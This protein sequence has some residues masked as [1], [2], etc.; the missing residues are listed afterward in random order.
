MTSA[1]PRRHV[2]HRVPP[3]LTDSLRGIAWAEEHDI[4]WIDGNMLLSKQG[5]IYMNH[6]AP[7]GLAA[8]GFLPKGDKRKVRNLTDAQ[9]DSL[10]SPD[11][12]QVPTLE[13]YIHGLAR[14]GRKGELEA[15]DDHRFELPQ[16]WQQVADF[17]RGAWGR[18]W[19]QHVNG[20]VLTNLSGGLEYALNVCDAGHE[21]GV[22]MIILPRKGARLRR[23]ARPSITY[24]HGGRV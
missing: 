20:K 9:L 16:T 4:P 21:A 22:P 13:E 12:Y 8:Q 17:A 18:S 3:R 1:Y 14:H 19:R 6:G 2:A 15:K 24:N 11:G 5:T 10:H 7:Y 23:L